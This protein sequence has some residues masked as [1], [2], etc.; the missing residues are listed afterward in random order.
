MLAPAGRH[1]MSKGNE[2]KFKVGAATNTKREQGN[3]G[4]TNLDHARNGMAAAHKS[5]GFSAL[6]SF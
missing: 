5:L 6:R 1:L 4:G 2:L 3:E